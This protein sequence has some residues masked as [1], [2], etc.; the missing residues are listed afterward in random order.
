VA[1][2]RMTSDFH[3]APKTDEI[4]QA[5]NI[6]EST[7]LNE[8]STLVRNKLGLLFMPSYEQNYSHIINTWMY[9]LV[10]EKTPQ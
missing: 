4:K 8:Y 10:V 6:Y 7:L 2:E 9:N 3:F 5:L 1:Y